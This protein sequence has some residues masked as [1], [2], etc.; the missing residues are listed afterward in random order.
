MS[1]MAQRKGFKIGLTPC[2]STFFTIILGFSFGRLPASF[3]IGL[4]RPERGRGWQGD[5]G[6][7]D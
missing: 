2:H 3:G 1:K 5:L 7:L 4:I 6:D